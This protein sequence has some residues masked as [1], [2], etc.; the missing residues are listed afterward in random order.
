MFWCNQQG[1]EGWEEWNGLMLTDMRWR[2]RE[3]RISLIMTVWWM[4]FCM[5][6]YHMVFPLCVLRIIR[7]A[8][9]SRESLL[10][11]TRKRKAS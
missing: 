1:V 9:R 5:L 3:S 4:A 7:P 10:P 6:S 8:S 11:D 2:V